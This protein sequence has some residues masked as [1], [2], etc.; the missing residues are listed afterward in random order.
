MRRSMV[1]RAV[2]GLL[3]LGVSWGPVAARSPGAAPAPPA[4][5]DTSSVP[6][7]PPMKRPLVLTSSFGEYRTGHYHGGLDLSTGGAPGEPVLAPA[8]GWVWRVRASGVGYGR[9]VYFRLDD[10]RTVLFGHLS[11]FA[12]VIE[13]AVE[14]EQDR[15]GRYEV[16]FEPPADSLRFAA[17]E[18]L[19][20]SGSSGAGPP[21]LHAEMRRGPSASV[22][23][24]PLTRGWSV[25]DTVAPS[26]TRL[27]VVPAEAGVRVNGGL[28][29][30]VV[31]LT[32][33]PPSPAFRIDGPVRLWV[34]TADR[35]E[36]G[37]SRVAPYRVLWA[38][39]ERPQSEVRF[40]HFDWNWPHE[41]EWTFDEA[42]A[43]TRNE[44]WIALDPPPE[45]HQTVT[46]WVGRT[47]PF[48]KDL[49][50]G[51]HR[52]R[53]EA[54]DAAR[55]ATGREL[56]VEM[57]QAPPPGTPFHGRRVDRTELVSRGR[58]LV[59]RVAGEDLTSLDLE[60]ISAAGDTLEGGWTGAAAPG[61]WEEELERPVP[62]RRSTWTFTVTP[63]GASPRTARAAWV[64]SLFPGLHSE[65]VRVDAPGFR[66]EVSPE[67]VYGS[68]WITVEG[69]TGPARSSDVE[70]E[71]IPASPE[72]R[73][74][75]WAW[76]LRD[77]VR[78]TL[79]PDSGG[80]RRGLAVYRWDDGWHWVGADTSAAGISGTVGNLETLALLRDDTPPAVTLESPG[81]GRRPA[82]TARV[83]DRG[84]GVTWRGLTMTLDGRTVIAEWNPEAGSFT[85]HLR[86]SLGPGEHAWKVEAVDRVG[87]R[88]ERSLTVTIR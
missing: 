1:R 6:L 39:D 33:S 79:T 50:P 44:R 37:E 25:P 70:P 22:A 69:T 61:G 82:L 24:N 64:G 34:E 52:L 27:R 77:Q 4:K 54:S 74:G 16:D 51:T 19:G 9:A 47:R 73:L 60:G 65:P 63:S 53:F 42:L 83:S 55:N 13:A 85:A 15:L 58:Y 84:A 28:D 49:A 29:P 14:A 46:R 86:R 40:D 56:D 68:L 88:T 62:P 23:V 3:T 10:G 21:H 11:A 5:S 57:V 72:V 87:N 36:A 31:D 8:A 18:A 67:A 75:P 71:L 78:V 12:P 48:G 66:M 41:V 43:R 30:V 80:S 17:G 76:P 32:G 45:A 59:W 81:R 26:L 38:V 7:D 35:G 20:R 2:L